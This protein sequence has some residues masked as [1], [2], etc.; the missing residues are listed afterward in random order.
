MILRHLF[1]SEDARNFRDPDCD[2]LVN[3]SIFEVAQVC[4]LLRPLAVDTLMQPMSSKTVISSLAQWR[5]LAMIQNEYAQRYSRLNGTDEIEAGFGKW[6]IEHIENRQSW[7]TTRE[8][9]NTEEGCQYRGS[10]SIQRKDVKK[11]GASLRRSSNAV[12]ESNGRNKFR[13]EGGFKTL[14]RRWDG[15]KV[16]TCKPSINLHSMLPQSCSLSL[17]LQC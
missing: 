12:T 17:R 5:R 8:D 13:S 6:R 14:E 15:S 7:G 11:G 10:M 1:T 9:V 2:N 3:M 4:R 16:D